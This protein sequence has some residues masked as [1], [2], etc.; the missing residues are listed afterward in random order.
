MIEINI[1]GPGTIPRL[2]LLDTEVGAACLS[3][4]RDAGGERARHALGREVEV[5]RE[6]VFRNVIGSRSPSPMKC[7]WLSMNPGS[8][9]RPLQSISSSPSRPGPTPTIRPSS[10]TTSPAAGRPAPVEDVPSAQHSPHRCDRTRAHPRLG[11]WD[12]DSGSAAVSNDVIEALAREAEQLGYTSFWVNDIPNND[13]L[14][15]LAAA[16]AGT[17]AIKL[18]VGVI[19]L[20]KRPPA[21]IDRDVE[22]HATARPAPARRR[23]RRRARARWR[24]CAGVAELQRETSAAVVVG[25]L[26]PKMAQLAGEVADGV[27]LNWM[28]SEYLRPL[29]R[30]RQR[31]GGAGSA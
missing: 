30:A 11:S 31:S 7:T 23:V 10:I 1:D 26:G 19:P 2:G 25:A 4:G 8:T 14:E 21:T 18:G 6:R 16:A 20:D 22:S 15:S 27:L 29:R 24:E 12:A 17:T 28:T 13:G 5:R 3:N 9:V